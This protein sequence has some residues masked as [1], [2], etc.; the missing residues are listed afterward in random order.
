MLHH[1]ITK[2]DYEKLD[3]LPYGDLVQYHRD[4]TSRVAHLEHLIAEAKA[5][6]VAIESRINKHKPEFVPPADP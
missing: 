4:I 6:A 3:E 1:Q 2:L 5:L